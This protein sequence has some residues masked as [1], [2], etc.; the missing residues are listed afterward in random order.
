MFRLRRWL[1]QGNV[2]VLISALIHRIAPLCLQWPLAQ[3]FPEAWAGGMG[4]SSVY[5]SKM[6]MLK[7]LKKTCN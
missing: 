2:S 6:S 7:T 5:F 4:Q 3:L 1:C